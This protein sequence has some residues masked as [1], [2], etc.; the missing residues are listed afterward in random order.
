MNLK[1]FELSEDARQTRYKRRDVPLH[2]INI[3]AQPRKTF[4]DIDCLAMDIADKGMLNPPIVARFNQKHCRQYIN[5][6]NRLWRTSFQLK[7]LHFTEEGG[8]KIFYVL[9]AGERR[10]CS[11]YLLWESGCPECLEKHGQEEPGV[12]FKRHFEDEKYEEET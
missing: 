1:V 7:D 2:K 4:L 9:L 10:L 12:C 11:C 6:I 8:Q 3:L 5:V